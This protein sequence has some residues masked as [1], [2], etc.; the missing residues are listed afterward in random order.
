MGGQLRDSR[1]K[2]ARPDLIC[3]DDL[4]SAKNTNTE[5]LRD[6]NLHWF[7]SVVVPWGD[8]K[9]TAIIYMGTLVHGQGLLHNIMRRSGYDSKMYSAIISEPVHQ[10]YWG[11]LENMLRDIDNP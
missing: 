1:F 2:N 9:K 6:K 11:K 4:E 7:N 8:P 10:D 5:D 3:C